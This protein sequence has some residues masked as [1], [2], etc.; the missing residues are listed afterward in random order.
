MIALDLKTYGPHYAQLRL[1]VVE[2]PLLTARVTVT[3]VPHERES[4]KSPDELKGLGANHVTTFQR[5]ILTPGEEILICPPGEERG[6][7]NM[8]A[9]VERYRAVEVEVQH[10]SRV[11]LHQSMKAWLGDLPNYWQQLVD[12]NIVEPVDESQALRRE[13]E[14]LNVQ[15]GSLLA[16]LTGALED[17]TGAVRASLR[18]YQ[19]R[20]VVEEESWGPAPE[21]RG[22]RWLRRW[23]G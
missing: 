1:V 17:L 2:G 20:L 4:V 6:G 7:L 18:A 11:G 19:E 23:L 16:D 15:G 8:E 22:F 10:V 14:R 12:A 21:A 13:L 9:L 3:W 5:G